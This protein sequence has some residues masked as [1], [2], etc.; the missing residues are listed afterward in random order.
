[1]SWQ[2]DIESIIKEQDVYPDKV[3]LYY[4]G[5]ICVP[6]LTVSGHQGWIVEAPPVPGAAIVT[7]RAFNG[8]KF[9]RCES[10]RQA[11]TLRDAIAIAPKNPKNKRTRALEPSYDML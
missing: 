6:S 11:I 7:M 4:D 1:M 3:R 8:Y 5:S 2:E 10:M 9:I